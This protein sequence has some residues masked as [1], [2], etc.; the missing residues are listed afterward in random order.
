MNPG[1]LTLRLFGWASLVVVS[2][3]ASKQPVRLAVFGTIMVA[4]GA[5]YRWWRRPLPTTPPNPSAQAY[6][7]Q[8]RMRQ[9]E[10]TGERPDDYDRWVQM[11]RDAGAGDL[12]KAPE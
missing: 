6:A 11:M 3:A 5:L 12:E 8:L 10:V 9:R 7:D 2:L 4:G 1:R